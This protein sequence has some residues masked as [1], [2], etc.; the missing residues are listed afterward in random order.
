MEIDPRSPERGQY[1]FV[2]SL[3]REVAYGTLAKRERRA[4]HLAAARYFEALGE[5]ELAG[6]L[7]SHYL[8]AHEASAEGAEAD[9]VAIQARLALTGAAERAAT[10]GAL[11]QAVSYLRQAIAI[12]TDVGEQA[13]LHLRAAAAAD[14][15]ALHTHAQALAATGIDLARSIGDLQLV[16][17]GQALLGEIQIDSGQRGRSPRPA[18]QAALAA[19]RRG[20]ARSARRSLANLSR[21]YMRTGQPAK[22]SRLPI[23][24]SILPNTSGSVGSSR[25]R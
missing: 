9:A 6:A 10:L 15:A 12:T 5:D 8:A 7:A 20:V 14:A 4:R 11:D 24:R 2:Q 17:E 18:L 16:G 25:R 3:I 23:S 22:S 19:R 21:A 13:Q 1:R